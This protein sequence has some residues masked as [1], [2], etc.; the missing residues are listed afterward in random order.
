[1]NATLT[2]LLPVHNAQDRLVDQIERLLDLL[3]DMTGQFEVVIIDDGSTDDTGEIA[4]E[5]SRFF[6]QVSCVRHP[7]RL[8]LDES[9][10][11]GLDASQGDLVV[12]GDE[13]HG[14]LTEDLLGLW[15]IH[16][17]DGLGRR[18]EGPVAPA[19]FLSRVLSRSTSRAAATMRPLVQMVRRR[20]SAAP[21]ATP[22]IAQGVS[23][24]IDAS[25]VAG[26]AAR[27]AMHV[28]SDRTKNARRVD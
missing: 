6:P 20:E 27:P 17:Q 3:P 24:R 10:Q 13:R 7:E 22:Q 26:P 11:S 5:L 18:A 2:V 9:I 28:G 15:Q 12:V 23:R 8:G 21:S 19:A 25:D 14:I 1:M 16:G 4:E